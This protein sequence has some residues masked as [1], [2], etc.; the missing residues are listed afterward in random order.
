MEGT[1]GPENRMTG[2]ED[3][4]QNSKTEALAAFEKVVKKY[5]GALLRYAGRILS[6]SDAV[7]D[8][9][10][11][12]FIKLFKNW[13]DE[14]IPSPQ[15]SSWLYRVVHNEAVDY[16]RKE[17]RRQLL[18]RKQAAEKIPYSPPKRGS[19]PEISEAAERAAMVLK[20]LSMR[21][22][23]VVVLKVYE[24]Q[25][26]KEISIIMELSIGNVGYILHHAMKKMAALLKNA[27]VI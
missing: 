6:R 12:T 21:E 20:K 22:Q 16:L 9:A 8:V 23:Q 19:K 13:K 10:Q 25:S 2:I 1:R 5:E 17:S 18:H 7:Q 11:N 3:S 4:A 26:Y 15:L 27:S 24:E 14:M